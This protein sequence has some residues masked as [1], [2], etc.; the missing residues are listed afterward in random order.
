MSQQAGSAQTSL[1]TCQISSLSIPKPCAALKMRARCCVMGLPSTSIPLL[2]DPDTRRGKQRVVGRVGIRVRA[3]VE[4][5]DLAE[6]PDRPLSL[7]HRARHQRIQ[8][9]AQGAEA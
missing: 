1:T 9:R 3:A 4:D 6:L 7:D 5:A 2:W 8:R